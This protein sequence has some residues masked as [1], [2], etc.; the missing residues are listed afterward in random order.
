MGSGNRQWN[1]DDIIRDDL[2]AVVAYVQS[3]S[4]SP[5]VNW[6]GFEMGGLLLYGFVQ[7]KGSRSKIEA[8]VTIGAPATFSHPE[9]EPMKNLLQLQKSPI[10]RKLFLYLDG[11]LV[12]RLLLPAIPKF[13]AFFLN[14]E[15]M[16]P[17]VKEKMLEFALAPVNA[18]VLDHI[19]TVI[20]EGEFVSH[21]RD[22]SYRKNLSKLRIPILLI[23]GE[24]DSLAPP[25]ALRATYRAIKSKDPRQFR[26]AHL[27]SLRPDPG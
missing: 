21:N 4:R 13:E 8:L 12:G 22:Y 24:K 2:E 18:G 14:A 25:N 23:G 9:Q 6:V 20:R 15:N 19:T 7:Q 26:P 10:W 16:D 17:K 3:Q 5:R 1:L 11:P 27:R